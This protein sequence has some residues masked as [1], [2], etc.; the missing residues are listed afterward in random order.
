MILKVLAWQEGKQSHELQLLGHVANPQINDGSKG[1][2]VKD[3]RRKQASCVLIYN[4]QSIFHHRSFF[5]TAPVLACVSLDW[6]TSTTQ[7][8]QSST[9]STANGPCNQ[10]LTDVHIKP[11]E[12]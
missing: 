11:L 2:L 4:I 8:Y 3:E 6:C 12:V 5:L 7:M 10:S 9:R 1:M